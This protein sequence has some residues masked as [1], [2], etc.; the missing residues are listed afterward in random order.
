MPI[1][2]SSAVSLNQ[3]MATKNKIV[4]W[5]H[6]VVGL[7]AAAIAAQSL[8]AIVGN[9][10]FMAGRARFRLQVLH[11]DFQFVVIG[12]VCALCA[13][14]ILKW[15]P[16]GHVLALGLC[17]LGKSSGQCLISSCY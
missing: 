1:V 11:A 15:R 16:W 3:G 7:L 9:Y 2:S 14:G 8:W 13:W 4:I 12:T 5:G 17:L 10:V 6:W